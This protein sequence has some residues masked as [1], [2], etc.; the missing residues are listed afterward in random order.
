MERHAKLVGGK[1]VKADLAE[2]L[3]DNR[4]D[5]QSVLLAVVVV[6]QVLTVLVDMTHHGV[7]DVDLVL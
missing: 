4:G 5:R 7:T 3:R 2:S 1:R 6:V